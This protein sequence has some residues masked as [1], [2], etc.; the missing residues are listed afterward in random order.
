MLVYAYLNHG[1]ICL[2][3]K[4][5]LCELCFESKTFGNFLLIALDT[6][7]MQTIILFFFFS[8]RQAAKYFTLN[9]MQKGSFRV[10]GTLDGGLSWFAV[11]GSFMTQF[12]VMGIH[13]VF[14]LLYLDLLTEFG[15]SKATTG[16]HV[17]YDFT[18]TPSHSKMG[19]YII[20]QSF[21]EEFHEDAKKYITTYVVQ[22]MAGSRRFQTDYL[23][24]SV[25]TLHIL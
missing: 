7:T 14:G 21:C 1:S 17:L 24:G 2:R 3:R 6:Y 8:N 5:V 12:V 10:P 22:L 9:M 25:G 11:L 16:K 20:K 15:Q 19:G 13:N 18:W 4:F 23:S